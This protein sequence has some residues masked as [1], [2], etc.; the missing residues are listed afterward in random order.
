MDEWSGCPVTC[1]TPWEKSLRSSSVKRPFQ[2]RV[3]PVWDSSQQTRFKFSLTTIVPRT[4]HPFMEYRTSSQKGRACISQSHFPSVE[5]LSL[6][7]SK[8][9]QRDESR[10]ILCL[11]T[12]LWTCTQYLL[13]IYL[14]SIYLLSKY[15]LLRS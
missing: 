14:L 5:K 10:K 12:E 8:I 9:F 2:F 1:C 7:S 13:S 15:Y 3:S 4:T 11:K 6:A